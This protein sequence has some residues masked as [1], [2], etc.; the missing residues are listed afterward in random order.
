MNLSSR[1]QKVDSLVYYSG[2]IDFW[3][4]GNDNKISIN[5]SPA[6]INQCNI[7]FAALSQLP[8]V[9][10]RQIHSIKVPPA[11]F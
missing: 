8:W 4:R 6:E 2:M 1:K 7:S 3:V 10:W 11:S 9:W 5:Q